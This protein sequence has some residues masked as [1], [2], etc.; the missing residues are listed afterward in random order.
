MKK[1]ITLSLAIV[2]TLTIFGEQLQFDGIYYNI[3][4][5][6]TLEVAIQPSCS[7]T[8]EC[9]TYTILYQVCYL[10]IRNIR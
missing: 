8:N 2:C 1:I 5:D 6:S 4:N 7:S 3:L 9:L 10:E